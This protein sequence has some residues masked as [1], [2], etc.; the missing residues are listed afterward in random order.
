MSGCVPKAERAKAARAKSLD[1][2]PEKTCL[3]IG[4][5]LDAFLDGRLSLEPDADFLL[6]LTACRN[7][8]R[9]FEAR[10]SVRRFF[11]GRDL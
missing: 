1:A 11:R 3:Q 10:V 5:D 8:C 4:N 7:C 6:H 2:P 9:A